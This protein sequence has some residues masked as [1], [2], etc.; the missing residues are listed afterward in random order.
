MPKIFLCISCVIYGTLVFS[1]QYP[2]TTKKCITSYDCRFAPIK[3]WNPWE[4][5]N[6][7]PFIDVDLLKSTIAA[8]C[9]DSALTV[10]ERHRNRIGKVHC[11]SYDAAATDT[12]PSC[13]RSIGL[14]D[15]VKCRSR[16]DVME[17]RSTSIDVSFEPKIVPGTRIPYPGFPSIDVLPIAKAERKMA[18][19]NCFGFP[20]KY[21]NTVLTLREMPQ[22]PGAKQLAENVIGKSLF[23][24]WPMMHEAKVS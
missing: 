7:L 13:D 15:I 20:S 22:L 9:P 8:H 21:P 17:N 11:Y 4:G 19:V 6:I 24:N 18:G 3:N 1:E 12:V 16:S 10:E 5:V 14:S 23:V 2:G